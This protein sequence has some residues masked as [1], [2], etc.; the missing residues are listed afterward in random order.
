MIVCVN[1]SMADSTSSIEWFEKDGKDGKDEKGWMEKDGKDW[2][3][4]IQRERFNAVHLLSDY[5]HD[6]DYDSIQFIPFH[7]IPFHCNPFVF[8]VYA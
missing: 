7:F 5:D 1:E 4:S 6:H 3:G 2:Q 8:S